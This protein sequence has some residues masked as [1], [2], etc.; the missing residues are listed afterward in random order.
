MVGGGGE[1]LAPL[2]PPPP[3]VDLDLS[4]GKGLVNTV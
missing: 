4:L 3:P 2:A 1:I